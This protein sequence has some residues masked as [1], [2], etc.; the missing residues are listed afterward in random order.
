MSKQSQSSFGQ[1]TA[2]EKSNGKFS[3][4]IVSSEENLSQSGSGQRT[5]DEKSNGKVS[6]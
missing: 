5:G 2:D 4:E 1:G 6:F 3:E